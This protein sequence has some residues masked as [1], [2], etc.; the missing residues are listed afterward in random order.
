M[1]YLRKKKLFKIKIDANVTAQTL[2]QHSAV[3]QFSV[4]RP[5]VLNSLPEPPSFPLPPSLLQTEQEGLQ[6][7]V[8]LFYFHYVLYAVSRSCLA[9]PVCAG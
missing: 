4:A 6:L 3:E 7:S 5:K 9:G 1:N 2:I 8:L